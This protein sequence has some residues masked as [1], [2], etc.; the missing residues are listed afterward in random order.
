MRRRRQWESA[1]IWTSSHST[2]PIRGEVYRIACEALRNAFQ[3]SQARKIEVEIQYDKRQL[4]LRV[5]DNGKGIDPK[6]LAA[7]GRAGHHG[8]PGMQERAKLV[9]GKLVVFSRPDSGTEIE[10]T[11]PASLAYAKSPA[12]RRSMSAG[13]GVG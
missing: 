4:R 3:H 5:R 6:I 1:M 10:L 13:R 12:A 7:G 9:G 8:L 2:W 11:V